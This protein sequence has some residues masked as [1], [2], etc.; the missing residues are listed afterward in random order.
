MRWYSALVRN[1]D[2]LT[3]HIQKD[4]QHCCFNRTTKCFL[5]F[6]AQT[7]DVFV[8]L[9]TVFL[10]KKRTF[11]NL[12]ILFF[13]CIICLFFQY[14]QLILNFPPFHL[15]FHSSLQAKLWSL[16]PPQ[17]WVS[18]SLNHKDTKKRNPHHTLWLIEA[19]SRES[20]SIRCFFT[21]ES[22]YQKA[23]YSFSLLLKS[24]HFFLTETQDLP[25][26]FSDRV[27]P[28]GGNWKQKNTYPLLIKNAAPKCVL[29]TWRLRTYSTLHFL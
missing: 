1:S 3:Y 26:Q 20:Q 29:Y 6:F 9:Q 10:F 7:T 17:V 11:Y 21:I 22:L 25:E 12:Y 13:Y 23:S 28:S 15:F 24:Y 2:F 14:N 27:L 4:R 5:N 18:S 19:S 8:H 16:L